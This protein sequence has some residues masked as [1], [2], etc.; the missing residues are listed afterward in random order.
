LKLGI[1]I[2][3]ETANTAAWTRTERK[4]KERVKVPRDRRTHDGALARVNV[5][6]RR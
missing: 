5:I 3:E 6:G 1:K 2:L 4:E